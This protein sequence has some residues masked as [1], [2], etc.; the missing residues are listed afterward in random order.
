MKEKTAAGVSLSP[1]DFSL[2][3]ELD[4]FFL[5]L[6]LNRC[7]IKS[8]IYSA[9]RFVSELHRQTDAGKKEKKITVSET[10]GCSSISAPSTVSISR[11]RKRLM[12]R[13]SLV[14]VS[15]EPPLL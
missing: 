10:R 2:R 3:L 12:N 1:S 7:A 14:Q 6:S 11:R 13:R 8:Q 9:H 5:L 15:R 4:F